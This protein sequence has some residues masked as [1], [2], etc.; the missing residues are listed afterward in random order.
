MPR[1]VQRLS[2]EL[3]LSNEWKADALAK[4]K[5]SSP[6]PTQPKS[7]NSSLTVPVEIR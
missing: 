2:R 5:K 1:P 3:L 6:I 7:W 4:R